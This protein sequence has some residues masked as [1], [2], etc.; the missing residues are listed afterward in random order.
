MYLVGAGSAVGIGDVWAMLAA[1][2]TT[3]KTGSSV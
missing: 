1:W 2:S 3:Q